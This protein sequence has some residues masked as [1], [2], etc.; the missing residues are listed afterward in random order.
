M[1]L[2]SAECGKLGLKWELLNESTKLP[3]DLA[4]LGAGCE[5]FSVVVFLYLKKKVGRIPGD[6][7]VAF[8]FSVE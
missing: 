1:V 2:V 3:F 6:A 4:N 7:S 5:P 8:P